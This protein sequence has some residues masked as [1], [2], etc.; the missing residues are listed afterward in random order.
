MRVLCNVGRQ[1][2]SWRRDH[3]NYEPVST[4]FMAG[5]LHL[6]YFTPVRFD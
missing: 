3:W 4:R 5:R 6:G 2:A 1:S